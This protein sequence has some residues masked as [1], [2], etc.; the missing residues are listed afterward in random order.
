[1][2]TEVKIK[3]RAV[4]SDRPLTCHV[5][6]G[7]VTK[8]LEIDQSQSVE[9][10]IHPDKGDTIDIV[11]DY[12]KKLEDFRTDGGTAI[13][14][15]DIE[16]NSISDPKILHQ[17]IFYPDY[18]EWEEDQGPLRVHYLGFKG[19]WILSITIPAYTWLHE[20]LDLGWHY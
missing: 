3:L 10:K 1:M 14:I 11:V 13:L 18:P 20:T 9:F 6:V 17:G 4:N 12:D 7:Y 15:E 5:T 16:I 8:R 2:D 19:R